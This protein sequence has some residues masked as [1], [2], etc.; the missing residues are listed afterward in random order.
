MPTRE[1]LPDSVQRDIR[2]RISNPFE[3]SEMLPGAPMGVVLPNANI[4]RKDLESDLEPIVADADAIESNLTSDLVGHFSD[5]NKDVSTITSNIVGD[6][7]NNLDNLEQLK[8][9]AERKVLANAAKTLSEAYAKI[10]DLGF[11]IP[12]LDDVMYAKASGDYMGS[13][14]GNT[15]EPEPARLP[16]NIPM[17]V[18]DDTPILPNVPFGDDYPPFVPIPPGGGTEY[19]PTGQ[20]IPGEPP[21]GGATN[22]PDDCPTCPL[23]GIVNRYADTG[24][25]S[26]SGNGLIIRPWKAIKSGEPDGGYLT[27]KIRC[28]DSDGGSITETVNIPLGYQLFYS[29]N[30]GFVLAATGLIPPGYA[31][32]PCATWI[33]SYTIGSAPSGAFP[34]LGNPPPTVPGAT[35]PVSLYD[36]P[37]TYGWNV[38]PVGHYGDEFCK[39]IETP[40]I[41]WETFEQK[42]SD[43]VGMAANGTPPTGT[44]SSIIGAITGGKSA[45]LPELVNRFSKWMTKVIHDVTQSP[46][47]DGAKFTPVATAVGVMNFFQRWAGIIPPQ[48]IEP[49]I[50]LMNTVCQYAI[51]SPSEADSAFLNMTI[52]EDTWKCYHKA[53]GNFV[54]EFEHI[55]NAKRTKADALQVSQLYRREQITKD[56]YEKRMR[57]NGVLKPED[58]KDIYNL[59]QS[60]PGISD[61]IRFLVRDIAD[62]NLV[63]KYGMYDDFE[64]KY[65]GR[66]IKYADAIGV[67]KDLMKDQ[68]AAHW[69]IPSFTMLTQMLYR[70]RPGVVDK[71]LEVTR[72]DVFEALKQDDWLP[73]WAKRMIEVSLRPVTKE[74]SVKAYMIHAIE[75]DELEGHYMNVGYEQK[76][77]QFYVQYQ[78]KRRTIADNKSSGLPTIRRLTSQFAKCEITEQEFRDSVTKLALSE[79]HEAK[80][81]EAGRQAVKNEDRKL[82]VQQVKRPF[83]LGLIDYSEATDQ[84]SNTDIDVRCIRALVDSWALKQLKRSKHLAA[85]SLCKM[86]EQGIIQTREHI[87]ALVRNNWSEEDATLIA[88]SCDSTI[89][90]KQFRRAQAAAEKARREN[91]RLAKLEAKR[92]KLEACGPPSCPTNTPG[93]KLDPPNIVPDSSNL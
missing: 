31:A 16:L 84:L 85:G 5:V 11:N 43:I 80:M 91:E 73:Y 23:G 24:G 17:N 10:V 26:P 64:Q 53:A 77:A 75:D 93:G 9:N 72:D 45:V 61:V 39:R 44:I 28:V 7:A 54:G 37:P 67:S 15:P 78:K 70:L 35:C 71:S 32:C 83:E 42:F 29:R 86:R 57:A 47:C 3:L 82:S 49:L 63:D 56:D 38:K 76:A 2:T 68:W 90:E 12:T 13:M 1:E 30:S 14:M 18:G 55:F 89:S 87:L 81:L 25:P 79:D 8:L 21:S 34:P 27:Y 88:M 52:S 36:C 46:G 62:K 74:D 60:W 4:S 48:S 6:I 58:L 22:N 20:P 51:P 33:D 69:H 40:D 92:L 41:N 59:T 50:Q 66:L 19:P 65:A